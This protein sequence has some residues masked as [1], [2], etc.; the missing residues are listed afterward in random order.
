MDWSLYRCGRAGHVT[1]A[2]EEADLRAQL[3]ASTPSGPLWRC[4]RCGTFVP[5]EPGR[6]GPAAKAPVVR[7]GK[8]LRSDFILRLFAIERFLRFLLFGALAYGIY[9]FSNAQQ[10]ISQVFQRELPFVRAA[11]SQLG[12]NVD[13]SGILSLI[14]KVL[15]LNS[16]RLTEVAI[17]VGALAV[18]SLIE[19]V[20]LWLAQRWG[21][22]FAFIV[23]FL[24][25]P[26]EIY[27]LLHK[28][29]VS[30]I[31]LFVL[32]IVLVLYL[33]LNRRLFGVRGGK[34]AY[35]ARVRSDSVLDEAAKAAAAARPEPAAVAASAQPTQVPPPG[36]PV[37]GPA[38]ARLANQAGNPPP[39][40]PVGQAPP[41]IPAAIRPPARPASPTT[42]TGPANPA[43]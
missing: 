25:L 37:A 21:E 28:Q 15:H 17:A 14:Q 40:A 1:Y 18:I 13:H 3:S 33:I 36:V 43:P 32:N 38:S 29:T 42:P 12:Y 2:P 16:T 35:E 7:R 27:E 8:E 5:G 10:N 20:G 39:G 24:G 22:Y 11:A 4:L 34:H 41:T 31:A 23:T 26:I 30:K 9:R 19:G 6:S